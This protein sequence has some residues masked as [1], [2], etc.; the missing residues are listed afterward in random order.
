MIASRNLA[1]SRLT[2]NSLHNKSEM[3]QSLSG[4]VANGG[5][6][7]D[8]GRRSAADRGGWTQNGPGRQRGVK[9]HKMQNA[10]MVGDN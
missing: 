8:W 7:T 5:G 10:G 1:G 3:G 9:M 2:R 6:T 4:T